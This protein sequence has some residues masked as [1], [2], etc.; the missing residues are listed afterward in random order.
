M[1][2]ACLGGHAQPGAAGVDCSDAGAPAENSTAAA[3]TTRV[4]RG[5]IV[6]SLRIMSPS[7]SPVSLALGLEPIVLF[8]CLVWAS[9]RRNGQNRRTNDF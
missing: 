4:A 8:I 5:A 6:A 7:K 3:G 9:R 1:S 2:T